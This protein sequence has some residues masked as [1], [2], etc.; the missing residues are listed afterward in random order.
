[1]LLGLS[2]GNYF[3]TWEGTLVEVSL[4]TLAGLMIG[5]WEGYLVGLSLGLTIG[6]PIES[7]NP[8]ADLHSTLLSVN[9]QLWFG[10]GAVRCRCC[11]C[12]LTNSRKATWWGV[13]ISCVPPCGVLVTSN[14]NYIRY[15]QLLDLFTL[16]LSP[17][18]L[19]PS[20]GWRW[21]ADK[22]ASTRSMTSTLG[23]DED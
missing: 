21:R 12:R 14:I 2:L 10:S 1:M 3:G 22:I 13:G 17:T 18:W 5:I 6:S 8:G 7:L 23:M 4:G 16:E 15:W 11:C 20:S 9:L 19:I